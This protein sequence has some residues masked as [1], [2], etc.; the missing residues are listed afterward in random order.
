MTA[1]FALSVRYER[2][3]SSPLLDE[4]NL[5]TQTNVGAF[6]HALKRPVDSIQQP[7]R[8]STQAAQVSAQPGGARRFRLLVDCNGDHFPFEIQ[9]QNE[10]TAFRTA[11]NEIVGLVPWIQADQVRLLSCVEVGA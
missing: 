6:G 8:R 9:T 4:N 2:L 7:S 1:E 10:R 11:S 3:A 5:N